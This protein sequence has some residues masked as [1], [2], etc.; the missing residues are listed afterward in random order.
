MVSTDLILPELIW[1]SIKNKNK[2]KADFINKI[3]Y[4]VCHKI[5]RNLAFTNQRKSFNLEGRDFHLTVFQ[6]T[7]R[8]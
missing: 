8:K 7:A 3:N 2:K 1:Q 6:K 4:K 5:G